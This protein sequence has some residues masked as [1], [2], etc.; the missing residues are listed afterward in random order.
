MSPPNTDSACERQRGGEGGRGFQEEEEEEG[1]RWDRSA[2]P[3][4]AR[5]EER[6]C[7][8]EEVKPEGRRR[9]EWAEGMRQEEPSGRC[10]AP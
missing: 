1:V 9:R 7:V 2:V 10:E 3:C 4:S 6:R 5:G 8:G